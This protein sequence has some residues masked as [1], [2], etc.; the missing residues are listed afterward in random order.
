V[1]TW[2]CMKTRIYEYMYIRIYVC[3]HAYTYRYVHVYTCAFSHVYSCLY[4]FIYVYTHVYMCIYMYICMYPLTP[5]L[6]QGSRVS[7]NSCYLYKINFYVYTTFISVRILY[8]NI[9][10]VY[11]LSTQGWSNRTLAVHERVDSRILVLA[12]S[13]STITEITEY[14]Y[15]SP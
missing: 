12:G 10:C 1:H 2:T 11:M 6:S 13:E 3:T 15:L 5:T 7:R 9:F 8:G 4:R 14:T